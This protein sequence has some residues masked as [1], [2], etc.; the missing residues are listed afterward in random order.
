MSRVAFRSFHSMFFEQ[1]GEKK[2]VEHSTLHQLGQFDSSSVVFT[3]SSS[4]FPPPPTV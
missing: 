1:K 3:Q 2:I 4:L